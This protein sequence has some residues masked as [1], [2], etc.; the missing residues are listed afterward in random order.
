[1]NHAILAL[2]DDVDEGQPLESIIDAFEMLLPISSISVDEAAA[3]SA[4]MAHVAGRRLEVIPDLEQKIAQFCRENPL[5]AR[6]LE[7]G[8]EPVLK[9]SD[10]TTYRSFRQT[11]FYHEIAR[12]MPGW[13]DQ[14]AVALRLPGKF[15]GFGLNRDLAFTSE[16]LLMLQLFQPHIEHV[17]QRCTRYLDLAPDAP[18][19][20]RQRQILHW[21][22]E[23]K[24]DSDI[25]AILKLSVRTV[26]QHVAA[27]LQKLHVETRAAA[28]A[29]VWRARRRAG[30]PPVTDK[31]RQRPPATA[32]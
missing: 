13:R 18:L 11:A 21:L 26:E 12:F 30:V 9:I 17:L 24:R 1:M 2:H 4:P 5:V 19:T 23:G 14:A 27:C 10:F 29:E 6:V 3:G 25:A 31:R 32:R 15:I 8:F 22:S 16:E 20:P 7:G 28:A